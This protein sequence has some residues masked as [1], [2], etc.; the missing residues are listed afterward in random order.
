MGFDWKMNEY[1][2]SGR[3]LL[4]AFISDRSGSEAGEFCHVKVGNKK[5]SFS[6]IR[7]ASLAGRSKN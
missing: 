7:V 2:D 6:K 4:S 1:E 5:N 3:D